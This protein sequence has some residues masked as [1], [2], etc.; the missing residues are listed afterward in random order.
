MEALSNEVLHHLCLVAGLK[1]TLSLCNSNANL[2]ERIS[3]DGVLWN[4]FANRL[5]PGS[6]LTTKQAILSIICFSY[7]MDDWIAGTTHNCRDRRI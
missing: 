2:N 3:R 5:F 1:A 6:K 4:K 7:E